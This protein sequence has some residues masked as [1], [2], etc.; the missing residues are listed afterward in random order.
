[1]TVITSKRHPVK[2]YTILIFAFLFI[3]A[4]GT[5]LLFVSIDILQKDNPE[6]K[7]YFLPVLSFAFYF[8][9]FSMVYSYCKNS[10]KIS[11][12]DQT[13]SFGNERFYLKEIKKVLLTGKMPFRFIIRIPMEGTALI[14]NDG[15]EKF[16]FDDMYSNSWEIKSFLDQSIIN[17][18]E[19][20]PYKISRVDPNKLTFERIETYKGNQFTSFRGIF[21]WGLIGFFILL[22][23]FKMKSPPVGALIFITVFS[24]FW[25]L[26]N[27]W[28]MHFFE[29]TSEYLIVKNHNLFW[30][31]KVYSFKDIKEVV[32]ESQSKQPNCL[33]IITKDYK[34]RLYPAGTLRDRTWLELKKK[35][36]LKGIRVRNECIPEE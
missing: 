13:I 30:L 12:D 10:P 4:L 21:L 5:M 15:K 8:L 28:L 19:Y 18:Q 9:A 33:R 14:F 31:T 16:I 32:Y 35:F 24:T 22:M 2:F 7:N 3:A 6:T 34:N 29:L 11:I 26:F 1:M 25:F 23:I 36:E 17:K 20:V 27:S